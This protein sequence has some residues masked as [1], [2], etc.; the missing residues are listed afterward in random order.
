MIRLWLRRLPQKRVNHD[1]IPPPELVDVETVY[2]TKKEGVI[3]T[4]GEWIMLAVAEAHY[5]I[6][7]KYLI[8]EKFES[9]RKQ[10]NFVL[11]RLANT[12]APKIENLSRIQ[13]SKKSISLI[14]KYLPR[15]EGGLE[16]F[17]CLIDS[18]GNE[19]TPFKLVKI[20]S[21]H[22][23]GD[24]LVVKIRKDNG[25]NETVFMDFNG[26]ILWKIADFDIKELDKK[27]NRMIVRNEE[28][29]YRSLVDLKGN[30]VVKQ[31]FK[32]LDFRRVEDKLFYI[33]MDAKGQKSFFNETGLNIIVP[34]QY[35]SLISISNSSIHQFANGEL[36]IYS[37]TYFNGKQKGFS[38]LYSDSGKL[39]KVYNA[40]YQFDRVKEKLPF[41]LFN[42]NTNSRQYYINKE[43]GQEYAE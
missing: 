19:L 8:Q 24:T 14:F 26:K 41:L 15:K 38:M 13:P 20:D 33:G 31:K 7:N 36:M 25:E 5:T 3:N 22:E 35:D 2:D 40:R 39:L 10:D 12:K 4:K 17:G 28:E 34:P 42:S 43:T 18:L 30:L 16:E 29:G 32:E 21:Y 1:D 9:Y 27:N 37:S 23:M 11:H 6:I